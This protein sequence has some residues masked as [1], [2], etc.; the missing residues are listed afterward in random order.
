MSEE[1]RNVRRASSSRERWGVL[2]RF[3]PTLEPQLRR[4]ARK[5]RV[6]VGPL[7]EEWALERIKA[8]ASP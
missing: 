3:E 8:E 1:R 6:G 4:L 5:R 7:L 2:V